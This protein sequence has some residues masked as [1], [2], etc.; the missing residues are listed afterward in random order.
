MTTAADNQ[1]NRGADAGAH[2]NVGATGAAA[3]DAYSQRVESADWRSV[4]AEVNE[5]GGALLPRLLNASEVDDLRALYDD[6][7][8]TP[9]ARRSTWV[10]IASGRDSTSTCTPPTRSRS[11]G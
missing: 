10:V 1:G 2:R 3:G 9:S 8:T 11:S 7:D 5:Y 6:A 4:T